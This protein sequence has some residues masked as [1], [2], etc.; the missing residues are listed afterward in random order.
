M[1][2]IYVVSIEA[3]DGRYWTCMDDEQ[4]V[5]E[6]MLRTLYR[7]TLNGSIAPRIMQFAQFTEYER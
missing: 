6:W 4:H 2:K 5:S 3:A 1:V 7:I